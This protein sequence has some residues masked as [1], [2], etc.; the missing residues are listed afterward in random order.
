MNIADKVENKNIAY[1]HTTIFSII[2][3]Q[4]SNMRSALL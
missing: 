3:C 4:L 1:H 2:F